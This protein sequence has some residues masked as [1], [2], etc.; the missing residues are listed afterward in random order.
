M[1][2]DEQTTDV[3]HFLKV[4]YSKQQPDA[5]M[6]R[7]ALSSTGTTGAYFMVTY[8]WAVVHM[9]AADRTLSWKVKL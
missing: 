3:E 9:L 4:C 2:T 6:Q 7:A 1:M 8:F 5:S